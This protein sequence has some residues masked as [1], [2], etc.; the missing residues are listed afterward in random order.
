MHFDRD[1]LDVYLLIAG[2]AVIVLAIILYFLPLRHVKPPAIVAALLGGLAAGMGA[3]V[4]VMMANGYHWEKE[5]AQAEPR[6][7]LAEGRGSS[8]RG[9]SARGGRGE[10]GSRM[11]EGGGGRA[12]ARGER[13][14]GGGRGFG[15]R[16]RGPSPKAQLATLVTKLDQLTHKPLAIQLTPQQK[17]ALGEQ[18]KGLA[19]AENLS[20]EDA[21][22]RLDGIQKVVENDEDTLR[23]AGYSRPGAGRGGLQA[24]AESSNPFKEGE[25]NKHLKSLQEE[26]GK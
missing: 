17:K 8:M 22:K 2:G 18:L 4:M 11:G 20:D 3:G 10:A 15:G 7:Q 21:Q 13:G 16:G 5:S 9:G 12:Q 23:A 14:G 26:T 19:E 24:P 1:S 25:N 6:D